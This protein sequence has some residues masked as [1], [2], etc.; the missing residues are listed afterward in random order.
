MHMNHELCRENVAQC[1]KWARAARD[2]AMREGFMV[3]A[4][5]WSAAATRLRSQP[6]DTRNLHNLSTDQPLQSDA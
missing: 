2:E 1:L 6:R 5:T 3:M 4:A